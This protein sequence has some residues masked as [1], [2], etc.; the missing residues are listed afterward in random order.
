V[1]A[2]GKRGVVGQGGGVFQGLWENGE[3]GGG[4]FSTGR[5]L[6][7]SGRV[8]AKK[9][10]SLSGKAVPS[11]SHRACGT[12]G[13]PALFVKTV[14]Y[15]RPESLRTRAVPRGLRVGRPGRKCNGRKTD[16]C[17]FQL[18]GIDVSAKTLSNLPRDPERVGR[19]PGV[20]QLPPPKVTVYSVASSLS[21]AGEPESAWKPPAC[22]AWMW[23]LRCRVSPAWRSW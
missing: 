13:P 15:P 11:L 6:P 18:V 1:G 4:R 17:R 10:F 3:G 21:E 16:V 7:Q 19:E 8:E 9:L 2:V 20:A 12:D 23:P 5:Q 14:E 22:T